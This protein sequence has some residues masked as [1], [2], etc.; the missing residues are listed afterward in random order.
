M[1]LEKFG[2]NKS[3]KLV[4]QLSVDLAENPASMYRIQKTTLDESKPLIGLK[5][6]YGLYGSDE[7]WNNI[8]NGVIPL[9]YRS[10]QGELELYLCASRRLIQCG[11]RDSKQHHVA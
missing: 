1:L 10:G 2:L 8:I 3:M 4:Y 9:V 7:W 5:G 11:N 6:T